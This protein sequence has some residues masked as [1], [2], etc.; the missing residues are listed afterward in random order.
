MP[1]GL[2]TD[3]SFTAYMS[4][5]LCVMLKGTYPAAPTIILVLPGMDK[6][7]FS[8]SYGEALSFLR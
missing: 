1:V 4:V 2:V 7:A 5:R 8:V 3:G 6:P